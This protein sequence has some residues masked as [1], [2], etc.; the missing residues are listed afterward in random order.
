VQETAERQLAQLMA[1]EAG[2]DAW[3]PE[4]TA[5][6]REAEEIESAR[7]VGV[8]SVTFL[9]YQ[10]GM[11]E[12][13][14]GLRRDLT[15]EIRRRRPEALAVGGFALTWPGGTLNQADHRAARA[16]SARSRRSCAETLA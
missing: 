14:L 1:R 4:R 13:G 9:G 5:P 2:I 12:Y 16:S 3:P 8:N 7:V 10:D 6:I 11:V 15:R